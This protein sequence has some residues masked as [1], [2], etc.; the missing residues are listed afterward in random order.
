MQITP[1]TVAM[2]FVGTKELTG[3]L[4]NSLI[5]A[6]IQTCDCSSTELKDEIP[7]C[8]AFVNFICKTLNLPRSKSLAARSWLG[9]GSPIGINYANADCD[10]VILKRGLNPAQGHVGFFAGE[11]NAGIH[12][13]GGNQ[14][15]SVSLQVFPVGDVVGVRRLIP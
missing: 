12:I 9:V 10:I 2:Q 14:N 13:L 1:L 15:N 7:W 6:M 5:L 3:N 4:D 8:S 11:D